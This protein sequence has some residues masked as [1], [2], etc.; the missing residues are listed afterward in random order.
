LAGVF[1]SNEVKFEPAV[2]NLSNS[3]IVVFCY[4]Y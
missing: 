4:K 2:C 1:P 3:P